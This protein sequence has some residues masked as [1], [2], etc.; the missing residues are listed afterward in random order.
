M[1]RL[2]VESAVLSVRERHKNSHTL[3]AERH[4]A[5]YDFHDGSLAGSYSLADTL[6]DAALL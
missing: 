3:V 6:A 2:L 5:E 1:P 4:C